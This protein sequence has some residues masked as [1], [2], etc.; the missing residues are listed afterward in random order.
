MQTKTALPGKDLL[1]LEPL[2]G[3]QI[4]AVLDTAG[5]FRRAWEAGELTGRPL[6]GVSVANLFFEPSTRTRT[7]FELAQRRLGAE[8]TSVPVATSAVRKGESLAD[9]ARTVE[10]MG[11]NLVVLRHGS[12]GAAHALADRIPSSVVNAGDGA[13][14]HPTQGLLDLL[15]LRERID[16]FEGLR[17]CVVGDVLHSRVARSNLFGLRALGAEVAFCG[18]P[19]LLPRSLEGLEVPLFHRL[20]DAL[21]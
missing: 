15:T 5:A 1:G 21:E 2:S 8:V 10:A 20:E 9:T 14:E 4:G 12:A 7:S 18:P 17:V 6:E 11:M 3:E 16:D 13:H 19:T